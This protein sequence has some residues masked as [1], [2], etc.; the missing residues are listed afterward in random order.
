MTNF[1]RRFIEAFSRVAAG[2]T[3]ML[4]GGEK[5]KFKEMKFEMTPEAIKFFEELKN[6]F[7]TALMLVYFD[8]TR[9]FM[10]ETNTSGKALG[11]IF[12]QL[13]E[14]TGQWHPVAFWSRKTGIHEKHYS[15]GEQKILA[16]VKACKH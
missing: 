8:P 5:G 9:R 10:L 11:I 6:C 13:I 16:I 3:D 4:K 12:S 2:L 7:Q 14:K 15:I 1:Y